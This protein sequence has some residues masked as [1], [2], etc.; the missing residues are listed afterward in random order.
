MHG[1]CY[2]LINPE[3]HKLQKAHNSDKNICLEVLFSLSF[4]RETLEELRGESQ[5]EGWKGSDMTSF[6]PKVNI[7]WKRH[8]FLCY[9]FASSFP[10]HLEKVEPVLLSVV[11]LLSRL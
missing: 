9:S 3:N 11:L 10:P 7:C 4:R 2:L 8:V 5:A 6:Q 1:M